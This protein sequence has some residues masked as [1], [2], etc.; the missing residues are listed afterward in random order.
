MVRGLICIWSKSCLPK[1]ISKIL[2]VND[3][4]ISSIGQFDAKNFHKEFCFEWNRIFFFPLFAWNSTD[5]EYR[6]ISGREIED[7]FFADSPSEKSCPILYCKVPYD[8]GQDYWDIWVRRRVGGPG[9]SLNLLP[10]SMIKS[11]KIL[12]HPCILYH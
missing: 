9:L 4:F 3:I 12:V 10:K 6:W 5:K 11:N 8:I 1:I 2:H 7:K